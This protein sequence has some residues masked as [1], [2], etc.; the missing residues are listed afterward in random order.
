MTILS[1][2]LIGGV[3]GGLMTGDW[4]GVAGG[5]AIATAGWGALNKFGAGLGA[6][7]AINKGFSMANKAMIG[8]YRRLGM[9]AFDMTVAGT[10]RGHGMN[11][12]N[13]MRGGIGSA[14]KF[15]GRNSVATNR[16]AGMAMASMGV[17]AG[18]YIGST[19]LKSNRRY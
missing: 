6:S 1:R 8:G 13:A 2:A 19:V 11:A 18:A 5:A 9:G 15:M 10:A 17:G 16:Y 14:R 7:R 12:L 3:A 4:G